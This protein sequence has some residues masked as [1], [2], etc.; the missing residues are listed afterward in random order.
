MKVQMTR[1][2]D[3][4]ESMIQRNS[5]EIN[6]RLTRLDDKVDKVQTWEYVEMKIKEAKEEVRN[7]LTEKINKNDKKVTSRID[8]IFAEHLEKEGTIGTTEDCDNVTL[9][10]Y[11]LKHIP[12][13]LKRL[14]K[15][16]DSV[17]QVQF[18]IKN[19]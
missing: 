19:Q 7:E 1:N 2:Q 3:Q 15:A 5:I 13:L 6:G 4:N 11:T 10:D 18:G 14:K 16:E 9:I 8:V 17:G 12:D